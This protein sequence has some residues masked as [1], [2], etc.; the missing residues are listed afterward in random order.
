MYTGF[1][2]FRTNVL[3]YLFAFSPTITWFTAPQWFTDMGAF[4]IVP[5]Q[6]TWAV[7]FNLALF[8]VLSVL[9]VKLFRKRDMT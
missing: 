4:A 6:E 7:A 3:Q 5:W 2:L 8:F 9:A 1:Y